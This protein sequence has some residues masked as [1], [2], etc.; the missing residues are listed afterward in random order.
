MNRD[1]LAIAG[2]RKRRV[3]IGPDVQAVSSRDYVTFPNGGNTAGNGITSTASVSAAI[4]ALA[5]LKQSADAVATAEKT[6]A[7]KNSVAF[8]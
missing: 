8:T 3:R 5:W 2:Y 6:T 4:I 1:C 7:R